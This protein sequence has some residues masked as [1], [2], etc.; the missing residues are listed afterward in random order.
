LQAHPTSMEQWS[1]LAQRAEA[2]GF[3][4]LCIA[5]HPGATCSPF[6]A[7][8]A[9]AAVTTTINLGTSVINAGV[10]QPLDVASDAATL[11]LLSGGRVILGL[12]AGHT[13]SEWEAT[14]MEYPSPSERIDRFAELLATVP[15][16]MAGD[17]VTFRGRYVRLQ[18]ASLAVNAARHV[19]LLVG[20]SNPRLLRLGAELADIVEVG[21]TG[22]TLPD[23]HYHEARWSET[24]VDRVTDIVSGAA[25][26]ADREPVLG[27]LVQYV[28]VTDDAATSTTQYLERVA[29][30]VPP[31][32][33]PSLDDALA[34]PYTL[35]GSVSDI[36]LKLDTIR[37][38]WGITRYT[39]R[40][41]ESVASVI[42][43]L[44]GP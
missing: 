17:T 20:G 11:D 35:V 37:E 3:A 29:A 30:V 25:A 21:G 10:R 16:L 22:R 8:A 1:A 36:L 23:G 2:A 19:P 44:R 28:E 7:L 40:S 9:A 43:A 14:G 32:A 26:R 38:R 27:A 18:E 15:R 5:D 41:L 4:A 42:D 24:E 12:G 13:P 39:V 34:A 6:V 31:A 33:L